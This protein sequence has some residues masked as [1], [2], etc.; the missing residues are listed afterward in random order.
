M[1]KILFVTSEAH[2]LMKTGGLGDV[3]GGLPQALRALGADVRL[4]LPGYHDA[5]RRAGRLKMVAQLTLPPLA[6]P[7]T[8]LEGVLPGTRV[9]VWLIDFPPAYD[10][11][12]NPYVNAHGQP[13]HD[14]AIRFALLAQVAV[15][16]ARGASGLAWRPDVVHAH[17]WQA[18]LVPALLATEA[19]RPATVF[20][21]HNLAYQG[22]FPYETFKSLSLPASFWSLHA[23]EF[24]GQ[25]SFIKGGI[26]FADRITTVSPTYAREIQTPE[27]G[28]GLDG[29]LRH[30]AARLSGILNGI[31]ER[32]WN[33]A[34]DPHL[35]S[36]YSM[37]RLAH[38]APNKAA[39]QKE[40]NLPVY[41]DVA[42]LGLV[43]RLVHQKGVDILLDALPSL[44]ELPLQLV[45][46]GSGDAQYE[47]A[48]RTQA[49]RYPDRLAVLAGYDEAVA[50]RIQAG[51]DLFLM[52]SRFEP[53][54]LSQLYNLRYGT[55]PIVRRVGGLA[56]TV[57]AASVANV[58]AGTATGIVFD[59]A[60]AEALAGAVR[61]A[62]ALYRDRRS[63]KQIQLTG[64][65]QDFSWRHSAGDYLRLY[66]EVLRTRPLAHK[67]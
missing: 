41:T 39:L 29:L 30:H 16:I 53:C 55:V 49:A 6:S 3:C 44:M 7:V 17:D 37:R 47:Q 12:G 25:L 10:R 9:K 62:L 42:M 61:R 67:E 5:L 8:L 28:Y 40:F 19:A 50:H 54:G 38:K 58:A 22:L 13:W 64:M 36:P 26:A 56:D 4:L 20:T 24:H 60:T 48:L 45:V 32:T 27:H 57:V 66:D 15:A 46:L 63:W 21:I 34:R 35:V 59:E 31:D 23:L 65:R 18:G 14:N 2:P 1:R 43:S 11:P 52:P 51:A 33:P